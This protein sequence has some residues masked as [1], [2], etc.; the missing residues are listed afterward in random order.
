M[1]KRFLDFFDGWRWKDNVYRHLIFSL[2]LMMA[3]YSLCRIGFYLYNTSSFPKMSLGNFL[4][5]MWG[6]LKFDLAAVLYCNLLF[7][8]LLIIPLN[9]R[10]NPIF[11]KV[12]KY[13]FFISNGIALA[14][15]VSD[16]IYYKFTLRRTTADV[17]RQ[18][19]HEQNL[20][21]LFGRFLIDYW[22]A[23][24]FWILLLV[25][26]VKVYN[27]IQVSGP[28]MKSK[29]TYYISGFV[30]MLLIAY[31][32]VGGI[33]GGFRESTRP[34]TLSNA[35]E[36]VKDPGDVS[37]VLNTPFAVLRTLGK[38]KV[39]R[40]NY[41]NKQ[42]LERIYNP[43]HHPGDTIPFRPDNVVVIVLES[44]SKEFIGYFNK[45]K[46]N[47]TYKGYTPFLDSL[48]Q[49]SLSFEHSFANGRKSI[50]GL[51]SVVSSIPSLGVPY[52]LS[53]Y[54]GNTINSLASLLK[55]KGY[56]SSFFH[57]APNGSMGFSAFMNLAGFDDYYGMD[58]Y[59][60]TE[61]SDGIWGI[62]DDKFFNFFGEKMN[63]FRQPFVSVIFSV[64]SHH[65][66]RVPDEFEGRFKGGPQ[67]ILKCIEYTDFALRKFF[68]KV[69][70][71]PWYENT[72]FVIT[73]DHCSSNVLFPEGH[74]A[75]GGFS[76]PVIFFKPDH[77]LA[78]HENTITQQIDILPSVMGNL[79]YDRNFIAFGRNVFE[80]SQ[81]PFAFNYRDDVYRLMMDNYLLMFDGAKTVALYDFVNDKMLTKNLKKEQPAAVLKMEEKIKAIIQQYNN[82]LVDDQMTVKDQPVTL[83]K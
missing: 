1:I 75:W 32:V 77:S 40:V 46:E 63:T 24:I 9:Y 81:Q 43:V 44:F 11:Q 30:S 27:R 45:E 37:I 39:K 54:S 58:E 57:G 18:F 38:T 65:P 5:L 55:A 64:S 69:S 42:E 47:G 20:G 56:Y 41:F 8:L 76:I 16:F 19:E 72:L 6:G 82:R 21:L 3:L 2:L 80:P 52:F 68:N 79:H 22:Y 13:L 31:L 73:A 25:V 34:I 15:N 53:P 74:T 71:M 67:P 14:A 35:G 48:L 59:G 78:G 4:Y 70:S 83:K 36:F 17:F 50:D 66:F 29:I 60:D 62:W 12:L 28:L 51:P 61:D 33:R 7:I 23:L 49:Y 10:F 26:L